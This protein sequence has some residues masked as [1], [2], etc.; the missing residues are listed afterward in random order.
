MKINSN[1]G[2]SV[3]AKLNYYGSYGTSDHGEYELVCACVCI[4]CL[5]S[6]TCVC[7]YWISR[8]GCCWSSRW[9]PSVEQIATWL[10][11][12]CNCMWYTNEITDG[13]Y[14]AEVV[15]DL[16][17]ISHDIYKPNILPQVYWSMLRLICHP[18][19]ISISFFLWGGYFDPDNIFLDNENKNFSGWP[20]RY[21]Y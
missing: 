9:Q 16:P 3:L 11:H 19:A 21:F 20:N 18:A 4:G 15:G 10:I 1:W 5:R 2:Y 14:T 12:N 8:I 17:N 6:K 13:W 7:S